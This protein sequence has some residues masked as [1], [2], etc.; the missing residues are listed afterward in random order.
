MNSDKLLKI[1]FIWSLV[2][3]FLLAVTAYAAEPKLVKISDL[4]GLKGRTVLISGQ[5]TD[6]SYK[7]KASFLTLNDSSGAILVVM[8]DALKV[9]IEKGKLVQVQGKAEEYRGETEIIAD[10]IVCLDC[11]E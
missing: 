7:S 11:G 1:A 10:Q 2:G 5:V 3:V 8:F 4:N 9:P 6:A